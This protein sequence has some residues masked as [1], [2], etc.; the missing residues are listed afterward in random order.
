MEQ[1][2]AVGNPKMN[3]WL[4][5]VMD[6][7]FPKLPKAGSEVEHF[8]WQNSQFKGAFT[9]AVLVPFKLNS[10]SFFPFVC[11]GVNIINGH[12]EALWRRW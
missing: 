1:V 12:T 6:R 8:Q 2:P 3:G 5:K 10:H 11:S 4:R 9:S 7:W